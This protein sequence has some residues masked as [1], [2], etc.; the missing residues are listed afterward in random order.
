M[1]RYRFC[2]LNQGAFRI[3]LRFREVAVA[4]AVYLHNQ[5][6]LGAK[7]VHDIRTHGM[8]SPK[9]HAELAMP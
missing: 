3:V 4:V 9:L 7:K 2:S 6:G 5:L 1:T 8:L